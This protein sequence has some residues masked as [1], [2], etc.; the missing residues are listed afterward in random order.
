MFEL[1]SVLLYVACIIGSGYLAREKNRNI[2]V[3]VLLSFFF[4]IFP[5][6][7]LAFLKPLPRTLSI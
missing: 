4:G 1:F 7:I 2:V 3:W 5:I 6:I